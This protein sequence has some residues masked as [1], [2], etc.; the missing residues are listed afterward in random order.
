[1]LKYMAI[2]AL[3]GVVMG[4]ISGMMITSSTSKPQTV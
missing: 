4:I 2:G 1:L 3:I